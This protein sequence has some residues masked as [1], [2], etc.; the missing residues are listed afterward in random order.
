MR[1]QSLTA[2][3]G[4]VL[5]LPLA[6]NTSEPPEDGPQQPAQRVF[7]DPDTGERRAPTA[8]E[9]KQLQRAQKTTAPTLPIAQ[10]TADGVKLYRLGEA[11]QQTLRARRTAA[12]AP[13][14][15]GHDQPAE[16]SDAP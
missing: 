2:A 9:L 6:A 16:E 15:I 8:E 5:L 10:R 14:V 13:L 1:R 7:I 4:A 11:H 3:L 12:D